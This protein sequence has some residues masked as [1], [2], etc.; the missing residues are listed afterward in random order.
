[1]KKRILC[2][3]TAAVLVLLPL[4]APAEDDDECLHPN[5]DLVNAK[6]P[7]VG[8]PG[9]TGDYVCPDCHAVL[10]KGDIIPALEPSVGEAMDGSLDEDGETGGDDSSTG[11]EELPVIPASSDPQSESQ[12]EPEPQSQPESPTQP[13]NPAQPEVPAQPETPVQPA[14]PAQPE[15]PA[16]TETRAETQPEVRPET[17]AQPAAVSAQEAETPPEAPQV[18]EA[19]EPAA[20]TV[21]EPEPV[22]EALPEAIPAEASAPAAAPASEPASVP[23]TSGGSS[24]PRQPGRQPF[25][26]QYPFRRVKM[27]PEPGIRAEA[28][29]TPLRP[30]SLSP[31][32]QMER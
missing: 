32:Q 10:K 19:P 13:E 23:K 17:P 28:A 24:T 14:V 29:G 15:T 21:P 1:M 11:S 20:E 31:L 18:P 9:Y 8:V 7:E 4:A 12:P 22:P 25:S 30:K 6:E 27:N 5:K 2:F 16:Q 3:L 26:T